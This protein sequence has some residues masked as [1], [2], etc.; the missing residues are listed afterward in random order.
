MFPHLLDTQKHC[1]FFLIFSW[2]EDVRAIV[3][4]NMQK[5]GEESV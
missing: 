3:I 2:K 4:A 1:D 5:F